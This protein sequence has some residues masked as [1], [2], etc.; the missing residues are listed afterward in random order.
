MTTDITDRAVRPFVAAVWL[1]HGLYNK[2]LGGSPRHLAIVQSVPGLAGV[3]GA[4]VL[5]AVGLFEVALALWI[6]SGRAPRRCAVTQTIVLLS[7]NVVE[8][9][10][11]RHLLLWPA[12]LLPLN[13]AFLSL[14]WIAA[15]SR[16]PFRL[17]ARLQRHPIPVEAHLEDCLTLTYALP[18]DVLRRLLPPGLELDTF[19]GYGF[20]AVA[21]VQTR[22]L[23]PAGLPKRCGQD[24]FLA[25]YRVFTRFRASD[26]RH[27]RG[28]RILRSDADRWSMVAGGNLFTHYNY[29]RCDAIIDEAADRIRV[30]VTTSDAIG[31]VDL[32]ANLMDT[33]LPAGSPFPTMRDARRFAGPLQFTFDYERETGAIVAIQATRTTWM[34]T[35]VAVDVRR[36]AFFDQPIFKGCTPILAAA[37]HVKDIDYRW[38]RGIPYAVRETAREMAS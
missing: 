9:T 13:I 31:R 30:S 3:T 37:F 35:P 29:H 4:R 16:W 22:S 7:M 18:P 1:V 15:G 6:L 25:G 19:G 20:V 33:T 34:P 8:L 17:R 36:V 5:A 26:G 23:R 32:T 27:L 38:E 2:L 28:L 12:G 10:V 21:L 14:A 11:A 24:F